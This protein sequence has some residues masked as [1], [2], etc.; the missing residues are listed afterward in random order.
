MEPK[1]VEMVTKEQDDGVSGKTPFGAPHYR[2]TAPDR[3]GWVYSRD[4]PEGDCRK[5]VWLVDDGG[6][7]WVGI[8][9][10][11]HSGKRWL[12]GGEPETAKVLCWQDLPKRPL[13][14]WY[15]GQL[16]EG[17]DDER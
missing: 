17:R 1:D 2:P 14:Y 9:A 12:N 5:L 7:C 10:F 3:R 4:V 8:R 11:D 15:R 16:L 6:M 13:R